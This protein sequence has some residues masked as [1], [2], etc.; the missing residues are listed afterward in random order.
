MD[1]FA[2]EHPAV[3]A[4]FQQPAVISPDYAAIVNERLQKPEGPATVAQNKRDSVTAQAVS[5]CIEERKWSLNNPNPFRIQNVPPPDDFVD[6]LARMYLTSEK[7]KDKFMPTKARIMEYQAQLET[8]DN[9]RRDAAWRHYT[10]T[11]F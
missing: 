2:S 9:N 10:K 1:F 3:H 6:I 7:M 11:T 5:A 4:E 8:P